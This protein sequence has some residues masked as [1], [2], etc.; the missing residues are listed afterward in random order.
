M[1][2]YNFQKEF[3]GRVQNGRKRCTIRARRKGGYL[4]K[5]GETLAL[6]MRTRGCK[7]LLRRATVTRVRPIVIAITDGHATDPV[8]V[9]RCQ[10]I[11]DGVELGVADRAALAR[12]DGFEGLA[13]FVRFFRE[14]HGDCANLYLIEW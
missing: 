7:L 10:I 4:P 13:D 14:K 12:R 11:L 3:S 6:Y 2:A 8:G 9:R 5:V 1:A